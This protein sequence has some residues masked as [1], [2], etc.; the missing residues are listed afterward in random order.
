MKIFLVLTFYLIAISSTYSQNPEWINYN[1]SNS[2]LPGNNTKS[3]AIDNSGTKW[4]GT[5]NGLA[6]FDGTTWVVYNSLNWGVPGNDVS[7][8]TIDGSGNKWM[9]LGGLLAKFDGTN[10]KV[11]P[12]S[13][14]GMPNNSVLSIA[15]DGSGNKWI[16]T[17]GGGLVKYD[18]TNWTIYNTSNSL[19]P[20]NSIYSIAIDGSGNKWVATY[21]GGLAKF[22]DTN[23]TIYNTSNSGIPSNYLC[24]SIIIDGSGNKWFGIYHGVQTDS[25]QFVKFDGTTWTVYNSLNSLI[26]AFKD[27]FSLAIDNSGNKWIGMTGGGLVKFDGT[28]WTA[29]TAS[30]PGLPNDFVHSIAV[31]S[32]GNKWIGTYGGGVAVFKEGGVKMPAAQALNGDFDFGT[33]NWNLSTYATGAAAI[34][35]IDTNS[36]ISGHNSAT[37]QISQTTGTD[38]HIQLWQWL[39]VFQGHKYTITFKAKASAARSI[40]L[41]LQKGASPYTTYL[42]KSHNL[43][44]QVQT[45][46]DE[47]TMNTTDQAVKL[48]FYLG[49]SSASV[50]IDDISITDAPTTPTG[51]NEQ[52]GTPGDLYL[53]QNYPNPFSSTTTINYKVAESGFVSIKVFNATGTEVANL[54]NEYKSVGDYSINWNAAGSANGVYFCRLQ[55]GSFT[56]TK[57]LILRK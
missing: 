48:Q 17:E 26:P 20:S 37:V 13:T 56:E 25:P 32:A 19:L 50:W 52:A 34:I 3:L 46:T 41:A 5:Q 1:S 53:H 21:G 8:I 43:T 47:V 14:P 15:I 9:S 40:V 39:S 24:Y 4:I 54:V 7:C 35:K 44:T 11:Y 57:K 16:G 55:A 51:I 42:Y 12:A 22:D 45:F 30:D 33:Q 23:W 18:G 49:N 27:V 29:Y 36:V 31:D 38:W 6:K 10:W 28:N 2:K